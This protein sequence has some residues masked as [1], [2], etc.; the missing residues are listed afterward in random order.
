MIPCQLSFE[1][2]VGG[3]QWLDVADGHS[4]VSQSEIGELANR[5]SS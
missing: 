2:E 5:S 3:F 4:I 1:T